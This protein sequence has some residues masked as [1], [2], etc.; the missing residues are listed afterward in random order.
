MAPHALRVRGPAQTAEARVGKVAMVVAT[1]TQASAR[2]LGRFI[3]A[4]WPVVDVV[5]RT[6][7]RSGESEL[8][9]KYVLSSVVRCCC[10]S[11]AASSDVLG[12][13]EPSL[14][15]EGADQPADLSPN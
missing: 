9:C 12:T 15:S 11:R 2:R 6:H 5:G 1:S 13:W 14:R 3:L 7:H 8:T 10:D 4:D